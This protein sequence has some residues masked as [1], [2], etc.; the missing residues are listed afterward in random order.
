M[1]FKRKIK[2]WWFYD[3]L[4]NYV[5]RAGTLEGLQPLMKNCCTTA[6]NLSNFFLIMERHSVAEGSISVSIMI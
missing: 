1:P 5:V 2:M 4:Y 3:E 6:L